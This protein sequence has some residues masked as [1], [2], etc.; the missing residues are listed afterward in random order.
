MFLLI[1]YTSTTKNADLK[2]ITMHELGSRR[3]GGGG[4]GREGGRGMEKG[5]KEGKYSI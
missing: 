5:R 1:N 2:D 4:G 3:M